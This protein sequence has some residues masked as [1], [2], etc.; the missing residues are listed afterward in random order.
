[1]NLHGRLMALERRGRPEDS[2]AIELWTE[3]TDGLFRGADGRCLTRAQIERLPECP[4]HRFVFEILD[5]EQ[6]EL[7]TR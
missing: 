5:G 2:P 7:C 4:G 6:G 3:E 1:M